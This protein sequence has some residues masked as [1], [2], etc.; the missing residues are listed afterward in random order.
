MKY[1]LFTFLL[2]SLFGCNSASIKEEIAVSQDELAKIQSDG[3]ALFEAMRS[4]D[5]TNE[6]TSRE[7]D[8]LQMA[9]ESLLCQ[10][11]YKAVRVID[12]ETNLEHIYLV[13]EPELSSGIQFGRHVRFDFHLG[14][15]DLKEII[16]STKSCLLVPNSEDKSVASFVTHL[17]SPAPSEFHVY[18]NLL[19]DQTIYVSTSAG[20]WSIEKGIITKTK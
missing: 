10:E 12:S 1:I 7:S 15:N 3:L 2:V 8:L 5:A 11:G 9:S 4:S 13:L 19:H 14:S 6:P 17:L 18:L 16:T 20:V